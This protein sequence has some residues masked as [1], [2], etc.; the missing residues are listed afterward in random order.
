M[1][2]TFRFF[3]S[4]LKERDWLEE[5]ARKGYL[6]KNITLGCFYKFE[7]CEPCEKVYEM[8]RF[9]ISLSGNAKKQELTA[10]RTALDIAKQMGWEQVTHDE[11]LNYYFVKDRA[12]D[13][14]DEFYDSEED[15]RRR[16]EKY[17][18]YLAMDTP[19]TLL[20]LLM[21]VAVVYLLLFFLIGN[22]PVELVPWMAVLI[23]FTIVEVG[24]SLYS[25]R[26][27]DKFY[28]ELLMSRAE[29]EQRKKYS[30][31]KQFRKIEELLP[32]LQERDEEG[33]AFV[34]VEDG[35]YLFEETCQH[36]TY[37]V[38]T[39][40]AMKSRMKKMG[41]KWRQEEKDFENLST[42]WHENSIGEAEKL[43][44]E[45]VC[46][47]DSNLIVYRRNQKLPEVVWEN[48]AKG[49]TRPFVFAGIMKYM[50]IGFLVGLIGGFLIV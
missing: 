47:V 2:N 25:I 50:I 27:G 35:A 43:G 31:E 21:V 38:D 39:Y 12:G 18:R 10:K 42:K 15:R 23:A 26:M 13:E 33:L 4:I 3:T 17:R 29:W 9:A 36:Y 46:C 19:K 28:K 44:I 7:E 11:A 6:L 49:S 32:F 1:K 48:G 5:M 45:A 8:E 34:C 14:S 30:V 24:V 20:G 16:A 41:K 22:N 37:Y 40:K